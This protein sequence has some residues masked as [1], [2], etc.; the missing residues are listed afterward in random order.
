MKKQ[1]RLAVPLM[2]TAVAVVL[3]ALWAVDLLMFRE[4]GTGFVTA[5][6]VYLRYFAVFVYAVFAYIL[7]RRVEGEWAT[8]YKTQSKQLFLVLNITIIVFCACGL[9][10]LAWGA[11][12]G[13]LVEAILGMLC[14]LAGV[15]F[16]KLKGVFK[17]ITQTPTQSAL[18]GFGMCLFFYGLLLSR[19]LIKPASIHHTVPNMQILTGISAV[20]LIFTLLS[21]SYLYDEGKSTKRVFFWGNL[22]FLLE[23]CVTLPIAVYVIVAKNAPALATLATALPEAVF[24]ILG[25]ALATMVY[26]EQGTNDK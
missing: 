19:F 6:S 5:G 4:A 12:T 18:V 8:L 3:G 7:S 13:N 24:G 14:I 20:G 21:S 26:T 15:W 1:T 23:C 22:A 25:L 9:Y 11:I 16:S 17:G 2:L 10:N